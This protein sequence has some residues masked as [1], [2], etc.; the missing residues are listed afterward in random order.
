MK[1]LIV[2][3]VLAGFS[4]TLKAQSDLET[5]RNIKNIV[6]QHSKNMENTVR[7]LSE[8]CGGF[9]NPEIWNTLKPVIDKYKLASEKYQELNPNNLDHSKA[10]KLAEL[11]EDAY[12][13]LTYSSNYG[14]LKKFYLEKCK[15]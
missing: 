8:N 5:Y 3:S 10:L 7:F 6:Q 14:D 11:L 13:E 9:D 4:F 2:L 15:K 1:K 12:N